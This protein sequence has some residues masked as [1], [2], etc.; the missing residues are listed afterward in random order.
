L[1]SYR[2]ASAR[3]LSDAAP[4]PSGHTTD[5]THGWRQ[6][7]W[8]CWLLTASTSEIAQQSEL[9]AL[10]ATP[11]CLTLRVRAQLWQ[12]YLP[13]V[14]SAGWVPGPVVSVFHAEGY[15]SAICGLVGRSNETQSTRCYRV[16]VAS[17]NANTVSLPSGGTPFAFP[18]RSQPQMTQL[19]SARV[20]C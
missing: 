10:P 5:V 15:L 14:S 4:L 20:S 17:G 13:T 11:T 6:V 16:N 18:I 8:K 3:C 1:R 7:P 19:N 2:P 12:S 9:G